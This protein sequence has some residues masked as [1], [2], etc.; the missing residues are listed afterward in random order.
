MTATVLFTLGTPH[1]GWLPTASALAACAVPG[2][3]LRCPAFSAWLDEVLGPGPQPPRFEFASSDAQRAALAALAPADR[4]WGGLDAR[5]CWA[6]DALTEAWPQA[7]FLVFVEAP[8]AALAAWL[9]AGGAG[10]PA[11][12][13]Q[14]W[15]AG[16]RRLLHHAHRYPARCLLVDAAEARTRV[17]ALA[18]LCAE[19]FGLALSG[20]APAP[21]AVE[22]LG[23][24]LGAA[25]AAGDREAQ[26]LYAE[27]HAACQPLDETAAELPPADAGIDA[28]AAVQRW[29][30]IQRTAARLRDDKAMLEQ[31]RDATAAAARSLQSELDDAKR[32]ADAAQGENDLLLLQLHQVQ[33]ELEHYYL[34]CKKLESG[35]VA[36]PQALAYAARLEVTTE[37]DTPP[38]RELG[39]VLHGAGGDGPGRVELRLVEH[40]GHP[41]LVVF[42]AEG[43]R[44]LLSV[45]QESGREDGRAYQ[46]LVPGDAASA[47][48]WQRMPSADWLAVHDL[49]DRI[50]ALLRQTDPARASRWQDVAARLRVQL[51]E[52]PARLRYDRLE[53]RAAA[54]G[55]G[56]LAVAFGRVV[57]GARR[58]DRLQLLWRPGQP[59]PVELP[60]PPAG[61][62]L[63]LSAWPVGDSGRPAP[64]WPLPLGGGIDAADGRRRWAA[65]PP[66]DRELLLG[67]LDALPAA[68]EHVAEAEIPPGFDRAA[69]AGAAARL[70][71]DAH[72]ALRPTLRQRLARL[73]GRRPA[74]AR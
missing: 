1:G 41:G 50:D 58:F 20:V 23:A 7:G 69:L 47:P 67:L 56:A 54:E 51:A 64:H 60:A 70:L 19:R 40:H 18:T 25:L 28:A 30:E 6:V 33:E 14:C 62:L 10:D 61:E 37:R 35:R 36:A 15:R 11:D 34:E 26:T 57:F 66:F 72:K 55:E 4:P 63:P 49:L 29:H 17:A 2:L 42:A 12:A 48:H 71:Q 44:Q 46:L 27:L 21:A 52:L 22:P 45:W 74:A 31:E 24:A 5:A 9:A 8:A 39:F 59:Q 68:A 13:L 32:R 53:V 73:L 43:P 3:D 65:L 16:A 38:H